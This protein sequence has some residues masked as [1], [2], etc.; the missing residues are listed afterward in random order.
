MNKI[1]SNWV[2]RLHQKKA[3]Y[4]YELIESFLNKN[5]KILDLGT[6]SGELAK[7][8]VDEGYMVT[9]VDVVDKVKVSG[10]SVT[11]Y[12]G[13]HLPFKDKEFE[14]TLL[15]TVLHHVPEYKELLSEVARVSKEVII[16]EDVYENTWD[17]WNIRF[18]DSVLNLEFFGHPHNNRN[19]EG[20][21]TIFEGLEWKILGEK[22][23]SIREIVYAFKQKAYWLLT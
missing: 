20:W 14:K 16:V 10:L 18:W 4:L 17:K 13:K 19:D 6:G 12:D 1:I 21:K 7:K 3:N 5:A 9:P 15:I 23:G 11:V 22:K 2:V 8:L